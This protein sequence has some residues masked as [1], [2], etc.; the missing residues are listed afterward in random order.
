M[1][2]KCC[3]I[4]HLF[5]LSEMQK[6][7]LYKIRFCTFLT[8]IIGNLEK[9]LV[10]CDEPPFF[11]TVLLF[12]CKYKSITAWEAVR[13]WWARCVKRDMQSCARGKHKNFLYLCTKRMTFIFRFIFVM[14]HGT[15][16][17]KLRGCADISEILLFALTLSTYIQIRWS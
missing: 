15:P 6:V 4:Y 2:P 9:T 5:A 8:N 3:G 17:F 13:I 14:W 10:K 1:L 12:L 16:L 7:Y 11:S